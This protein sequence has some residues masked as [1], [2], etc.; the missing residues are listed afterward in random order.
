MAPFAAA[1]DSRRAALR[2]S[3]RLRARE[4]AHR[5]A[6]ADF[7]LQLKT[8]TEDRYW[9]DTGVLRSAYRYGEDQDEE[10]SEA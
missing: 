5:A 2:R 1:P 7:V 10:E 9:L 8:V 6:D 3:P 4:A